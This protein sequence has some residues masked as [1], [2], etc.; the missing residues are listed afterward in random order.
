MSETTH[1]VYDS[2]DEDGEPSDRR[3]VKTVQHRDVIRVRDFDDAGAVRSNYQTVRA[4]HMP[5]EDAI[6]LSDDTWLVPPGKG[7]LSKDARVIPAR[8]I[9]MAW[10]ERRDLPPSHPYYGR[11]MARN[12]PAGYPGDMEYDD[13]KLIQISL[14]GKQTEIADRDGKKVTGESN[15]KAISRRA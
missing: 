6:R 8:D 9:D 10:P 11:R 3:A 7:E 1:Y 15:E 12:L 14:D 2:T 13:G 5:T 4:E